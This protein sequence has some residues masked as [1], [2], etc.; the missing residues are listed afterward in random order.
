MKRIWLCI[1]FQLAFAATLMADSNLRIVDVGLHGY[2]G[3]PSAV[4]LSV[5][6]PSSQTQVIHLRVAVSNQL[7]VTN[8]VIAE[9]N[10]QGNE[11]RELEVPIIV[12]TGN[13]VVNVEANAG[14]AVFGHDKAERGVR[15]AW[16][17]ALMCASDDVCKAAQSQIQF[18]G[19]IEDRVDKNRQITFEIVRD[20]REHWWAY[21][22]AS[23]V[24]LATPIAAL[25]AEQRDALE[26]FLRRGGHLILMEH[27]IADANFLSAYRQGKAPPNGERVGKGMLFRL[28]EPGGSQLGDAFA[29]PNLKLLLAQNQ[30]FGLTGNQ[31]AWYFS[32]F[33]A[34]FDFPRLRWV[35]IWLAVYT[36]ILGPINFAVLR[37]MHRLEYGWISMCVLAFVFAAG[38]YVSSASRR[39]KDFAL[40]NLA[41]YYMDGKSPLAAADY[42][43]RVSAPDRRNVSVSVADPAVFTYFTPTSD[44]ANSQ[45]WSAMNQQRA[46]LAPEF[47]IHLGPPSQMV[48]SLLKWSFQD[49][50]MQGLHQFPGTV[51]LIAPNRLRNDTG[52]Q[53]SEAVYI[54]RSAN[55]IY[56][57]P[58]VASGQEIQL[59][60]ITPVPFQVRDASGQFFPGDSGKLSLQELAVRGALGLASQA[61][62]FAGFS[63]GPALPVDLD[64][65][66]Q[67]NR[68]SL[69]LV[70][71]EPQ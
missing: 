36:I 33:I 7:E 30:R 64:V 3:T 40:D 26:E 66:H 9:V 51:H 52:Q 60:T 37:R 46:R 41:V 71:V 48:L 25:T 45:I 53:F 10:M 11:Q 31:T 50:T 62:A 70:A 1:A 32:R 28:S 14:G 58:P 23:A 6:N 38:F 61:R 49:L 59:D 18:S 42:E 8:T 63:D 44:E 4:R 21:A 68:H 27:E 57:L 55:S 65:A 17:V 24:V 22:P 19:T 29:G 34:P 69:I 35:L 16:L 43:L 5:R 15:I 39:P 12:P 54:D 47:D 56:A 67:E 20:P 13:M 2:S